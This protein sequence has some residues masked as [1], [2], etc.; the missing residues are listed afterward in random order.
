M[1]YYTSVQINKLSTC[2]NVDKL[3][4]TYAETEVSCRRIN[5]QCDTNICLKEVNQY[6]IILCVHLT[7]QQ[8]QS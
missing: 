5:T 3:E 4:G 2:I 1:E 8:V 7:T 6:H